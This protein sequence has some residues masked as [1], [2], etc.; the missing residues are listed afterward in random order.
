MT[1]LIKGGFTFWWLPQVF[2]LCDFE[3]TRS[4]SYELCSTLTLQPLFIF[5]EFLSFKK[6]Y[7]HLW[8]TPLFLPFGNPVLKS[9]TEKEYTVLG[10]QV[11]NKI[12]QKKYT[13]LTYVL[14]YP[15]WIYFFK[16][17][18][19]NYYSTVKES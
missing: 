1:S 16:K 13:L 18:F 3:W 2:S 7:F 11:K 17:F 19:N 5:L 9:F 10:N 4:T 8:Y 12:A 14:I 15:I 6:I